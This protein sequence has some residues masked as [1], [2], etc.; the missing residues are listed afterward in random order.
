MAF[1][2]YTEKH[3]HRSFNTYT[4]HFIN[5]DWRLDSRVL[6][7]S[8]FGGSHTGQ[9]LDFN[10]MVADFG[11]Q[12]KKIVC[13]TDSASNMVLACR[14]IGNNRIPCIAHKANSLIQKDFMAD[15]SSQIIRDLL[16]KVRKGQKKLLYR[17]EE[18]KSLRNEDNQHTLG[19]FFNEIADIEQAI[20]AENQFVDADYDF[21]QLE[22]NF[23]GMKAIN[24]IRWNCI[25]KFAKCYSDNSGELC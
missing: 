2:S 24:N 9:N 17:H 10:R 18:L 16:S 20:E 11:L 6:K 5:D 7:T 15:D 22:N 21:T 8:L 4:H 13:I 14:L 25:H 12:N 1:D 19:L 3:R 23:T